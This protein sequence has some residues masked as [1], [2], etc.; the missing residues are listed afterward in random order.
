MKGLHRHAFEQ[1]KIYNGVV[2]TD[3][4]CLLLQFSGRLVA[5]YNRVIDSTIYI[6]VNP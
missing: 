6:A 1:N 2:Y 5:N 3:L 4:N